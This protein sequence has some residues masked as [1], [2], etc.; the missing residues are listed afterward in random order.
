MPPCSLHHVE[1]MLSAATMPPG[2]LLYSFRRCPY[3]IRAR[4]ALHY[5]DIQVELQEVA[6]R[7]KPAAL[8]A[9]SPTGTVPLLVLPDGQLLTQSLDIMLWA[10]AQ[11]DPQAWL[12][13]HTAQGMAWV[14]RND[15]CFKPL[16]DCYK[17]AQ[18]HPLLSRQAHRARAMAALVEP[19]DLALRGSPWLAG[20]SRGLADVALLPF[21]RQ[22]AAVEPGWFE[23]QSLPALQTWLKNQLDE[24]LF[25][26]VMLR[27]PTGA[28]YL[29]SKH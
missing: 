23:A 19:L 21:V 22:F 15:D 4:M 20:Q 3:A 18:H 25:A 13:R 2:P 7:D 8:L 6:L 29:P 11:Q 26:A 27:P 1:P 10:L 14:Q 5:A 28:V 9:L 24:A 17:Y 12:P 16:L